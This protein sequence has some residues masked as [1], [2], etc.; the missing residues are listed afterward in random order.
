MLLRGGTFAAALVLAALLGLPPGPGLGSFWD[1]IRS[2]LTAPSC[3][4]GPMIDPNGCPLTQG[5]TDDGWS[6]DPNG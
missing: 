5:Q 1:W 6:I 2:A 4:H 3:D